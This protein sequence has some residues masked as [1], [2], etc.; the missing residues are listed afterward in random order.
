MMPD[1]PPTAEGDLEQTPF[2][3]LCVYALDKRLTGELFL[4]E[5]DGDAPAT[6]HTI[7]FDRGVPV[8]IRVGDAFARLGDLL[9]ED[10]VTTRDVVDGAAA[11]GGLLGDMLVLSGYVEVPTLEATLVKQFKLRMMRFFELPASTKFKYWDKAATLAEWGGDPSTLDP[12]ELLWA[13]VRAHATKSAQFESTLE[14]LKDTPLQVHSRADASRFN[15]EEDALLVVEVLSL[16]P[17]TI[18]EVL[19]VEDVDP[20]IARAVVYVL[21][22]TR[23]LDLGRGALPVGMEE[24]R[25][26]NLAKVRLQSQVHRRGAALDAPGD[27]VRPV[28]TVSVRGRALIPRGEDEDVGPAS[29]PSDVNIPAATPS[30]EVAAARGSSPALE[31]AAAPPAAKVAAKEASAAKEAPAAKEP[32]PTPPVAKEA[33]KE[34]P[35]A[36]ET[37]PTPKDPE[38]EAEEPSEESTRRLVSDT[39]KTMTPSALAKLAREKLDE[40]DSTTCA[41]VADFAIGKLESEK[42]TET[43][44]FRELVALRAWA[45]LTDPHSSLKA[46]TLDLDDAIRAAKDSEPL[47]RYVRGLLRKRLGDNAGALSDFKRVLELEPTHAAAKKETEALGT[48]QAKGGLLKKLFGR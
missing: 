29:T 44:V 46:A 20:T 3:H 37:A 36:K 13:G 21:A 19:E 40:K 39:L 23:Q 34:T 32:A 9:V 15:M 4:F 17:I 28:R 10:G 6:T 22:I 35:A 8:K 25:T 33:A 47:L 2:A 42:D 41:E 26:R 18:G 43:A 30:S 12:F 48:T 38:P 45:R 27:G 1:T 16:D 31:S 14:K 5:G 24:E 7:R 11:T